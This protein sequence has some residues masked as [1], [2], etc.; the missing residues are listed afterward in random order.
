VP[1]VFLEFL[2]GVRG[3]PE[4]PDVQHL[5]VEERFRMCFY[6]V[7]HGADKVL[8]FSASGAYEYVVASVNVAEY[9]FFRDELSGIFFFR[10]VQIRFA[11][12]HDPFP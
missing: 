12:F 2:V 8:R 7:D 6:I 11:V 5:G 1:E 4:S 10:L 9:F 3:N